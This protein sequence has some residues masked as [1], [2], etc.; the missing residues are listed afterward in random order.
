MTDLNLQS[1]NLDESKFR[2]QNQKMLLTYKSHINKDDVKVWFNTHF[3]SYKI[4]FIEIAHESGETEYQ[5]SHILIDWGKAFQSRNVR[6]FDYNGIHPNIKIIKSIVHW[7]NCLSYIAKQDKSLEH[8]S[9]D[10]I[11]NDIWN[12]ENLHEA[13]INNVHDLRDTIGVIN[14]FKN[15]PRENIEMPYDPSP[16]QEELDNILDN[17]PDSRKIYWY[18]DN[19]GGRGKTY[20]TK[21][22]MCS[23]PEK[24]YGVNNLGG[25]RD[26]G[27]IFESAVEAG[28]NG[29]CLIVNL[30]RSAESKS[31][32]EPLEM[33]KDGM[34]TSTKYQGKTHI[35]KNPHI[36]VFANWLPN[37]DKLS[38][39]RWDIKEIDADGT[40]H[41]LT[42]KVVRDKCKK[43]EDL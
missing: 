43:F 12:S 3:K 32:Y 11:V 41:N 22:K 38:L 29:H 28:W 4:K 17:I 18:Y 20:Y 14:I 7:N 8:F 37:V 40:A 21:Y 39:D 35:I 9:I 42:L 5:H 36:V 23:E 33:A 6:I 2:L 10:S 1:T 19:K 24:F 13:L 30:S 26:F 31:I 34:V 27:T 25:A 15:K 16:W